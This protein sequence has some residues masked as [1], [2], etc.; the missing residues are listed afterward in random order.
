ML[1]INNEHTDHPGEQVMTMLTL[2]KAAHIVTVIST[3]NHKKTNHEKY[4]C[5]IRLRNRIYDDIQSG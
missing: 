5:K 4:Q 3:N 2:K 1:Y